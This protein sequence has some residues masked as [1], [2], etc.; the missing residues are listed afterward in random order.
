MLL[1]E[2][3]SERVGLSLEGQELT[4]SK[5]VTAMECQQIVGKCCE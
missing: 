5:G 2:E 4:R 1:L 3:A